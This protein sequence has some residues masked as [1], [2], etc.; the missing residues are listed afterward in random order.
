MNVFESLKNALDVYRD[1]VRDARKVR[2][3]GLAQYKNGSGKLYDDKR[4]EIQNAY[5]TTMQSL[6]EAVTSRCITEIADVRATIIE[7]VK[8]AKTTRINDLMP[9]FNSGIELCQAEFDAICDKYI[10]GTDDYWTA[11]VLDSLASRNGLEMKRPQSRV[12]KQL[13]ALDELEK[14]IK[15]YV[16]GGMT[17]QGGS[18]LPH[19]VQPYDGARWDYWTEMLVS[20]STFNRLE[21]Q[22]TG[23]MGMLSPEVWADGKMADVTLLE[24]HKRGKSSC[25]NV[26]NNVLA[27][28]PDEDHKLALLRK[29]GENEKV[30][31]YMS[32]TDYADDFKAL[33]APNSGDNAK[34]ATNDR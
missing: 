26:I 34:G 15:T 20:D 2:D 17:K 8:G 23:D 4:A 3:D 1:S 24:R 21:A 31:E 33:N 14:N 7:E 22:Y 16:N 12:D 10:I 9:I 27:S 30:S 28:A 11:R 13:D 29:I 5:K 18:N 6:R 25:I 32:L 19:T